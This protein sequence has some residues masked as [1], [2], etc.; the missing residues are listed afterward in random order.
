MTAKR[1]LVT[2]CSTGIGRA[3]A[4]ELT[5]RGYEVIATAR[6]PETLEG[7]DAAGTLALDVDSD[8]SVAAAV[9]EA[10]PVDVLV[11]NAGF[12]VEGPIESVSL[13]EVRRMFETN[14]FGS[15]RRI[16]A[17]L[18]GMRERE[19]GAIVNVTSTAAI[20]APP[21]GGYYA[22]TKFAME[23]ISESLKLEAGHFGVRVFAI[24]PGLIATSFADNALDH[25]DEP[26]PYEELGT[27]WAKAMETLGGGQTAPGP[28]LVATAIATALESD[29]T[30]LRWPVGQDAEMIASARTGTDYDEFVTGMRAV[31][32]LDW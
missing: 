16:Q 7:I 20:A 22:A 1:A 23:A 8:S 27:L 29:G 15:I 4:I 31:L 28:E 19:S 21:L 6:R 30:R 11:N 24:E 3:T 25:R 32:G 14:V 13:D 9:A 18:P 10:G 17:V 26:G 2:G 5:K 12:G